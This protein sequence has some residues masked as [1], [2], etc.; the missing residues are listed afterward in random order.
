M[1]KILIT[2]AF[3]Q[4]GTE[5]STA[6]RQ[7]YGDEH[8]LAT[9]PHLPAGNGSAGPRGPAARLDVTDPDAILATLKRHEI[10]VIYH[11]AARLSAVGEQDPALTWQVNL[12]GLRNVLEA[13][14][15]TGVERVFWPSSIA[16]FG[17]DTPRDAVPQD[18][19]MRPTTIYGVTKVAGELLCDYYFRR[20]GLDVRGLRYPGVISSG[21]PPGGGT[22]DYAV[23]I[24]HAALDGRRYVAFL[25]EDCTL[26]MIYM[27]DCIDAAILLMETDVARLVHHNSFNITAMSFSPGELAAEIRKHIPEFRC[28]YAPDERQAIAESWPRS[29]D[30]SA[31]RAEWGWDPQYDLARMTADM[32]TRLRE[33]RRAGTP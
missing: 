30:D 6:L 13:A 1:T 21:A 16:A 29:L 17:P 8:V 5:L 7:R 3:G 25:R 12:D 10:D 9:G 28:E 19:V 22:T 27:P 20:Y 26:P 23:E 18:A 15:Q 24:F 11:L 14:R 32:L 33:R 2:G 4:I 31:A